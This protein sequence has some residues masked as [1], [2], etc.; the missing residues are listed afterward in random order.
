M[1]KLFVIVFLIVIANHLCS[2]AVT[3]I[4]GTVGLEYSY[5]KLSLRNTPVFDAQ[6]IKAK[7]IRSCTIIQPWNWKND[8]DTL[9]IFE[10]D[11]TGNINRE[12]RFRSWDRSKKDTI[13]WPESEL[14]YYD[15]VDT[16]VER[17]N[18]KTIITKYYVWAFNYETEEI[19]TSYIKRITYDEKNRM[20][21][22]KMDG[23]R[24][25]L[26]LTHCG[27]GITHDKKYQ[28]DKKDRIIG[29]RDLHW[30]EYSIFEHKKNRC[31]IRIYDTTT[32]KL[33]RK[34]TIHFKI[35]D[36]AIVENDGSF[37]IKLTRLNKGS[38][39][40]R[41]I[42]DEQNGDFT[43][44]EYIFIYDYFDRPGMIKNPAI[45]KR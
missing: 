29:Y 39:L 5:Q 3:Y 20:I 38:N 30:R 19:D 37:T 31:I 44:S 22:F 27:T 7:N 18:G 9:F 45:T 43:P 13:Y 36:E 11:A 12:I 40:F 15:R 16:T 28:Y 42:S 26:E 21:A 24:D 10:F 8:P 34:S 23:T 41:H 4:M 35:N 32:N 25:Y 14:R 17:Q 6:E 2:Q 1:K 33:V